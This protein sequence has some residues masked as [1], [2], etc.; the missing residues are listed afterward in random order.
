[1]AD[2]PEHLLFLRGVALGVAIAAPLGP[3]NVAMIDR[4]LRQ[5][6][7]AAFLLGLGS[8]V[9]DLAYI[10]VAYAGADPL[11]RHAWARIL[12]FGAG[13]V[14]LLWLGSGA[15]GAALRPRLDEPSAAPGRGPFTAGAL[16]TLLNPMSIALWLGLLGAELAGRPRAG[17]VT[18]IAYVAALLLGCLLWVLVLSVTLHY[19][20]RLVRR[21][22]LRAISGAAGAALIWFGVRFA[23]RALDSL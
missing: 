6:F 12:L 16:I 5:G 1:V 22:L 8:T 14:V 2:G 11:S 19:G 10:L 4:G 13:A 3:V 20:R 15:I 9:A 21:G 23:L 18:E 17:A 7:R